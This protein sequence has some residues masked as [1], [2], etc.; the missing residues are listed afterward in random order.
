MASVKDVTDSLK[1]K[2]I[3]RAEGRFSLSKF[4]RCFIIWEGKEKIWE[5]TMVLTVVSFLKLA[6]FNCWVWLVRGKF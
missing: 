5:V 2:F 1:P 3:P 6:T 4:H